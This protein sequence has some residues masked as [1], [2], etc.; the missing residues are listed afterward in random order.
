MVI[1][2]LQIHL[3][4]EMF[5]KVDYPLCFID[6]VVDEFQKGKEGGDESF[7]IPPSLFEI[8]NLF[9]FVDIPYCELYEIKSKWMMVNLSVISLCVISPKKKIQNQIDKGSYNE[10]ILQLTEQHVAPKQFYFLEISVSAW[11]LSG[12]SGERG[13]R[14]SQ[15]LKR[16]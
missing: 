12:A 16:I 1:F 3:I 5:M 14:S 4:K 15:K 6:S 9:I 8:T 7:V 2:I 11:R 10:K 13:S